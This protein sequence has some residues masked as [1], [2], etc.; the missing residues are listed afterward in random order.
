MSFRRKIVVVMALGVLLLIIQMV[1]LG[2]LGSQRSQVLTP[3]DREGP[4]D[5]IRVDQRTL[6]LEL[7]QVH[8]SRCNIFL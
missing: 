8:V 4:D 2:F 5:H 3:W 7:H 6:N 1:A